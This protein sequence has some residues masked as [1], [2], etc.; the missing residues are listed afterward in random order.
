MM[1]F[2]IHSFDNSDLSTL[3]ALLKHRK[4]TWN[5]SDTFFHMVLVFE[6]VSMLASGEGC[7]IPTSIPQSLQP[8]THAAC[9]LLLEPL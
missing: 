9:E 1:L 8:I 5:M 6:E 4:A 2:S 7:R 3:F